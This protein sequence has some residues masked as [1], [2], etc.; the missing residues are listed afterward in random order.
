MAIFF[1]DLPKTLFFRYRTLA[2]VR[3]YLLEAQ[4]DA[5]RRWTGISGSPKTEIS[6]RAAG[7][8]SPSRGTEPAARSGRT[9]PPDEPI[10]IVGISGTYPDA[11]DLETFWHNLLGGHD[12]VGEIPPDRW[13]LD[14]FFSR[15]IQTKPSPKARAIRNGALS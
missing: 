8:T 12:A 4:V 11:P 5:C 7:F 10:A 9:A 2:A 6:A 13:P 15:P 1:E 14:G 3:D